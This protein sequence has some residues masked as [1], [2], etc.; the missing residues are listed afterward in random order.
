M[1]KA[2]QS[3]GNSKK[4]SSQEH[5]LQAPTISLPKGGGAIKSIDEKFSVNTVNGTA[6]L[7]F[8]LPVSEGRGYTPAISLSY[9]SGKGNGIFGMGWSLEIPSIRRKT[10]KEL[11]RYQD[12]TDSDTYVLS[13]TEDLVPVLKKQGGIWVKDGR[14]TADHVIRYYR[15]RTE[16]IFSRIERWT[17][18]A[19]GIIHWRVI[20]KDNSIAIF[21]QASSARIVDPADPLKI[22][23]WFVEFTHDDK[24][25]CAVYEY[26]SENHAGAPV[27]ELHQRNRENGLSLYTNIYLKRVR[28]GNRTPYKTPGA[29]RPAASDYLF[30]TVFDFGEHAAVSPCEP[31][32]GAEWEYRNDAFSEYRSGF[33][34]RTNR[35][36]KSVLLYHRN[37]EPGDLPGGEALIKALHFVY[38]NNGQNGFTFLKQLISTGYTKHD[39]GHYTEKSLPPFE[40]S[41]EQ[42]AWNKEVKNVSKE[43]LLHAPAGSSESQYQWIDLYSEGISGLLT[44]QAGGLFYKSNLGNGNFSEAKPVAPRP[45]FSGLGKTLQVQ[46][47]EANGVKQLAQLDKGPKGFFELSEQ[48]EWQPFTTFRNF[49]NIDFKDKNLKQLDL[50]GDGLADLLISEDIVFRWYP[51][52]GKAGYDSAEVVAKPADEE[53][54]PA[55]IFAD[56]SQSIFIADMSGDGLADIVRIRNGEVC[57]WPNL[58]YGRFGAKVAMDASPLFD[59][60]D[61]FKPEWLRLADIDGSGTTDIVYLGKNKFTV[62]MNLQGNRFSALPVEIDPFPEM[63]NQANVSVNDLLGTGTSC[64]VWNSELPKHHAAPL[65]YIDLTS[66]RKPHILTKYKNNLGK[67]GVIEYTSSTQYYLADKK[68]GTPWITKLPFPVMCISKT[69]VYDRIRKTRFASEY[70]YHH[71]YYD[72]FEREFRGFGRVEQTDSEDIA[73]FIKES[74]GMSN[75]IEEHDLHQH[76][77]VTISWFHT[78][79]F[80]SKERILNQ[81]AHEYHQNLS[82]EENLLPEPKFTETLSD[83]EWREA[84]RACKGTLLRKEVYAKD[85]SADAGKPYIVQQKNAVIKRL[86]EQAI[87]KHAVFLVHESEAITYHYERN[88]ADPRIGHAFVLKID[89]Y[90]NALQTAAVG[91]GRFTSDP[92]LTAEQQAEQSKIHITCSEAEFTLALSENDALRSP[93]PWR[94]CSYEIA[95]VPPPANGN[96]YSFSE[97]YSACEDTPG[98]KINY[99]EPTTGPG[100]KKRLIELIRTQY[101]DDDGISILPFGTGSLKALIHETSK[102]AFTPELLQGIFDPL[103]PYNDLCDKL[104][105]VD[106]NGGGGYLLDDGY[107]WILSGTQEYDANHFFQST[108]FRDSFNQPTFV[109]YDATYRL[110]PVRKT[111]AIGNELRILDMNY[112]TLSPLRLQDINGNRVAVR[113]DEQGLITQT[114]VEGKSTDNGD[115]F[116]ATRKE[117]SPNDHA[118]VEMEYFTHEW[119]DQSH[120]PG[121]DIDLP[122][123][124]K[125]NYVR[126]QAWEAHYK[127]NPGRTQFK[128]TYTYS[129]GGGHVL[130]NKT[131]AEGGEALQV[132]EDGSVT[133]VVVPKRWIG[134]GRTI[135]NNKGNQVKQYEPYFSADHFFDD[136]KEMVQLGVTPVLHYDAL[137]RN[138]KADHPNGTFTEKRYTAWKELDYDENDT[139]LRSD[140]LVNV[141]APATPP[142]ATDP[143]P[144]GATPEQKAAWLAIQHAETP[145]IIHFDALGRKF[146]TIGDNKTETLSNTTVF[147]SEG[148]VKTVFDPLG[149]EAMSYKYDMLGDS[150]YQRNIDGGQHWILNDATGKPLLSW[151][152]KGNRFRYKYDTLHRPLELYLDEGATTLTIERF[153][154]GDSAPAAESHNLRSKIWKHY[155]PAGLLTNNDY[156]F[157]NNLL[158][159]SR[160][161][162]TDYKTRINWQTIGAVAMESEIFENATEYDALNRPV[163]LITPHT[164]T[165][166][167]SEI[168][169]AY[170][171]AGLLNSMSVKLRGALT[172]TPFITNIDYN[173]KGFRVFI[174]YANHT[175]TQ[176]TYDRFTWRLKNILSTRTTDN[177]KLQDLAY[178]FDPAGN[179]TRVY[180]A[181]IPEFTHAGQLIKPLNEY[182]HDALYRLKIASGREHRGQCAVDHGGVSGNYRNHSFIPFALPP[183]TNE[184]EAFR[185]YTESYLYDK[186][187]NMLQQTHATTEAG[188]GW[189]RNFQYGKVGAEMNKNNRL[190]RTDVGGFNYTYGNE[191]DGGYDKHGNMLRMEHIAEMSWDYKD[192]FTHMRNGTI[193]AYYVYDSEGER[194]R[195]VVEDSGNKQK[196]RL[197]LSGMEIYREYTPGGMLKTQRESLAI[198]DDKQRVALVETLTVKNSAV[199][200][201]PEML[202]RYEYANH[203]GSAALELDDAGLQISYEEYFPFGTT[204]YYS[205]DSAREVPAKRYR[206]TGKERDEESG[207]SYHSARYY[208][209]WLC[210]WTSCDPE[211]L[212]NYAESDQ[213]SYSYVLNRP[214]IAIDPDGRLVWFLV[215]AIVVA[216]VA[217]PQFANAPA[218]GQQTVTRS[219]GEMA[220]SMTENALTIYSAP[221]MVVS[222]GAM[223]LREGVRRA[224]PVIVRQVVVGQ[225]R[226]TVIRE[227]AN[228][229]DPSGTLGRVVSVGLGVR[230]VV[231][232]NVPSRSPAARPANPPARAASPPARAAS[233]PARVAS[234]PAQAASPPG[235]PPRRFGVIQGGGGQNPPSQPPPPPQPPNGG[236][237]AG[238]TPQLIVGRG[239]AT[240]TPPILPNPR[241]TPTETMA[242]AAARPTYARRL[243]GAEAVPPRNHPDH[244][245]GVGISLAGRFRQVVLERIG[246]PTASG[247]PGIGVS[248][249]GLQSAHAMLQ[250]NGRLL[251]LQQISGT[252][253]GMTRAQA[254]PLA[255]AAMQ[256]FMGIMPAGLFGRASLGVFQDR[257]GGWNIALILR[258]L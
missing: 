94:T 80:M 168:L 110:F 150:V 197:Y 114:F 81:Y 42:H 173:A 131:P 166:P 55:M 214:I 136:E 231:R 105:L 22:F 183:G 252:N 50:D 153:V 2:E 137:D 204:S 88:M 177:K 28:Y 38:N 1:E 103:I 126:A 68:K 142:A 71:G 89:A 201:A 143:L 163:K 60:Q 18:N 211:V 195:K 145:G 255:Q 109:E 149:R 116:D 176:Y 228:Q 238:A 213:Q 192:H 128:E 194:V 9:N 233:P 156:D 25:N 3:T 92:G 239:A 118:T 181:A 219:T 190:W 7:N 218:P 37:F 101:R 167:A 23:E 17:R 141:Y 119:Y 226:G 185:N 14:T 46:E 91:Y 97:I 229:V 56:Q 122:Y 198:L 78:G 224:A 171:E 95:N 256:Q 205:V 43:N 61:Q 87:N 26:I 138:I 157:K 147:D 69:I 74:G 187:G 170:N 257:S 47:L 6:A 209:P 140:W 113:Y 10:E 241:G 186:V 19:D 58:G 127:A 121:F 41:Y 245:R 189:T 27:Q 223:V 72:S 29:P 13:G 52:K 151:N 98:K 102:A 230:A 164:A 232:P 178:V 242:A 45:S 146:L 244:L 246:M 160:Q 202:Q 86:Q 144:A 8:P 31:A 66:S 59:A 193:D 5:L 53:K 221:R 30:E 77:A 51:S 54:G 75:N 35:L 63:D 155:D 36:C 206:Y 108:E 11:P 152:E 15:P 93:L 33:E 111:D 82:H 48:E 70:S 220:L 125:P 96:Y 200:A 188:S 133:V 240:A 162:C 203:L 254:L 215:A 258:R 132:N 250:P 165:I 234:P 99:H 248:N 24:H 175:Q 169:P 161:L 44:E 90:G 199:L 49:P 129:D 179:L 196:E 79:F 100:I 123:K 124:P 84:L 20:S 237:P 85:N 104:T 4:P 217:T 174:R 21:G 180:D 67:E 12:A 34:I 134:T 208:A 107:Y 253:P 243:E 120:A 172:A 139:V 135:L 32:P 184:A 83:N 158:S 222:G 207:F 251:I 191:A 235:G 249:R 112:R 159:V 117:Y 247:L 154:Y 106:V 40:L 73:H 225:V 182:T 65:R 216:V 57:Y 39:D 76:P 236:T 62:W 16:G 130:L 227:T 212:L 115:V 210:R 148:N 64:I